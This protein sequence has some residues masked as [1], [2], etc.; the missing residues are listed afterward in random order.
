MTQQA[1]QISNE[2]IIGLKSTEKN[3]IECSS[4]FDQKF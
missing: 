3:Q 4:L 2:H 1:I